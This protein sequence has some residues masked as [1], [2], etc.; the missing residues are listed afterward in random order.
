METICISLYT[1]CS[2]GLNPWF[3]WFASSAPLRWTPG[4]S[5]EM[6]YTWWICHV[7]ILTYWYILGMESKPYT[8]WW[9]SELP[10]NGCKWMFIPEQIVFIYRYWWIVILT[11]LESNKK[12]GPEWVGM[13]PTAG[14]TSIVCQQ[15][16]TKLVPARQ[17]SWLT[18][19]TT[20]T[21]GR[22]VYVYI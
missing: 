17:S 1:Q 2:V 20:R 5:W 15:Q 7:N 14:K 19:Q 4:N 21:Y 9:T 16:T 6:I 3:P 22:C 18:I 11:L 10:V 13:K 8:P 12:H